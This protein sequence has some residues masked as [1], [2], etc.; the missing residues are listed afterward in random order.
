[1]KKPLYGAGLF[2]MLFIAI[3][4]L[5]EKQSLEKKQAGKRQLRGRLSFIVIDSSL[6]TEHHSLIPFYQ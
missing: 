3:R 1:M 2:K 5:T 6:F 4:Q